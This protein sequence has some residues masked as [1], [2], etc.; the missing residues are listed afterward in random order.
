[1]GSVPPAESQPPP[2][3]A[4]R[5]RDAVSSHAR[6][7]TAAPA[8]TVAAITPA[9][10]KPLNRLGAWVEDV[11]S[12][13][14]QLVDPDGR[15]RQAHDDQRDGRP[16]PALGLLAGR[17][18]RPW[19]MRFLH[20]IPCGRLDG[21]PDPAVRSAGAAG[22]TGSRCGEATLPLPKTHPCRSRPCWHA[23][24]RR[25]LSASLCLEAV[26]RAQHTPDWA[27]PLAHL[28]QHPPRRPALPEHLA[29]GVAGRR[30]G[31]AAP[32]PRDAARAVRRSWPPPTASTAGAV[33]EASG[34]PGRAR[35]TP[36]SPTLPCSSGAAKCLFKGYALLLATQGGSN[37][38][39]VVGSVPARASRPPAVSARSLAR[40]SPM[41]A[42]APVV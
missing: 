22:E 27:P 1:M 37:K 39:K 6:L 23:L 31:G 8:A 13:T 21:E 12:E 15:D 26:R 3:A 19:I 36:C 30:V 20:G 4:A 17:R 7:P 40:A 11:Q 33:R 29:Q 9:V 24:R 10:A 14:A 25:G 16:E 5:L 42:P 32:R 41:P 34:R 28:R 18:D 35:A 2:R 38:V